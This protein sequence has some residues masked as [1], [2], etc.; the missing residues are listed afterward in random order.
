MLAPLDRAVPRAHEGPQEAA[1]LRARGDGRRLSFVDGWIVVRHS[2]DRA[3]YGTDTRALEFLVGA[4]LAVVMSG[5]VLN[6]RAV[7]P[8]SRSSGPFALVALAWGTVVAQG[9]RPGP[10]PRHLP[11]RRARQRDRRARRVRTRTGAVALLARAAPAARPDQLRR[12][13]LPL[14]GVHLSHAR[15]HRAVGRSRSPARACR[16]RSRSRSSRTCSSKQPIRYRR[17][18]VGGS[19]RVAIPA[20]RRVASP[21][22]RSIVGAA[23]PPLAATFAPAVSQASVLA[24]SAEATRRVATRRRSA[25]R[26]KGGVTT[27]RPRRTSSNASSSSATRSRSRSG[28]A[29]N[30]GAR[31]HGIAVL[32]DGVIGCPL[33]NGVDV[34]GYW[35]ITDPLRRSVPDARRTWPKFLSE[36]KP[37]RDHRGV[38]RVGR[39]RRVARRRQDVDVARRARRSTTTT[40]ARSKTRRRACTRPARACCGSRRRASAPAQRRRRSERRVVGPGARRGRCACVDHARRERERH[41][42]LRRDPQPGLPGRTAPS[43]PT[44]CTT[45]T[46]APTRR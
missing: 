6:R 43:G 18:I 2:I 30:A 23:A 25:T 34:R 36:F 1:R 27:P 41:G 15:A 17:R 32:N 5:R 22:L 8:W 28:A 20:R 19:R 13:H 42:R 37:D 29:S 35:G 7:A 40:R 44:A 33:L 24:R 3:Y 21:R 12:V 11:R 10:V 45:P 39:V 38:R 16:S 14:A 4:L 31:A 26:T 46:P 9:H